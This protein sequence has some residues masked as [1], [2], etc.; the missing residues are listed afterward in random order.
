LK[1]VPSKY[2]ERRGG[3]VVVS[4][5]AALKGSIPFPFP[6]GQCFLWLEIPVRKPGDRGK[7][8]GLPRPIAATSRIGKLALYSVFRRKEG[9]MTALRFFVAGLSDEDCR[10]IL[11]EHKL[12]EESGCVG[13]DSVLRTL[14]NR[15]FG[16]VGVVCGEASMILWMELLVHEVWRKYAMLY[17]E[18]MKP[19]APAQNVGP[20]CNHRLAV[21]QI[22][23]Y[24]DRWVYH[25]RCLDCGYMTREEK[26]LHA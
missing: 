16:E 10:L 24:P 8:V 26:I 19:L 11:E 1:G 12:L 15:F 17:L 22:E 23:Q 6:K 3:L 20:N 4:V 14:T 2:S 5:T 18:M 25:W 21:H 13:V 9:I 7:R